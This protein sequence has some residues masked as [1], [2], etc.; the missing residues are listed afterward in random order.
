MCGIV[1]IV[2]TEDVTGALIQGLKF[3]EYRGY[4]SAGIAVANGGGIDIERS[5]GKIA[6]LEELLAKRPLHGSA[7]IAH[8][9]WATHGVPSVNN[10]HPH[11]DYT[12][13]F[14]VVHNGII[15]NYLSLKEKLRAEGVEFSSDTDT[16]VISH[17]IGHFS[18]RG[19][20]FR[21]AVMQTCRLLVGSFAIAVLSNKDKGTIIA[22]RNQTP[23][24]VGIGKGEHFVASDVTAFLQHTK[25]VAYLDDGEM[26]VVTLDKAEYYRIEDG[27]RVEK[28]IEHITWNVEEAQKAGYPHYMLKEIHQQPNILVDVLRGRFKVHE[29]RLHM[30]EVEEFFT[31][32][33]NHVSIIA[34]GTSWHAGLVAKFILEEIA[35]IH[36]TVDYASEFRYRTP[37]VDEGTV[38][39]AISQSGETADTLAA[40]RMVEKM[41]RKAMGICNVVGSSIARSCGLTLYT[42]AGPEISVA[43][44]K[45]FTSQ[46]ATVYLLA[47][48]IAEMRGVLDREKFHHYLRELRALPRKLSEVLSNTEE[49]K[50]WAKMFHKKR[51]FLFLGRGVNYPV[52]LEGA[53]KLKEIS[54][55]HAEG[56]PAG[57]M[58]HGPIALI[59]D[60]FPTVVV[61]PASATFEKVKANL[62]EV[63]AREGDVL[64]VTNRPD[65]FKRYT[66]FVFAIPDVD[67]LFSPILT[68]AP[69]QLF[70]YYTALRRG[71]SID[72][73]RNL[74][75]SVVVE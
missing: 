35:R 68:T 56:Y 28:K 67:E 53:L 61:A 39:L 18:E 31:S 62:E 1:G 37:M 66:P 6:M 13:N 54:Y 36:T 32:D 43:S 41:G 10:A 42:Q 75:K 23:L 29:D 3:L 72:Q 11:I 26:A 50:R 44:T 16:E 5:Q 33:I 40:V 8:T 69:L 12:G 24:C 74:A 2:R 4:D 25:D 9:R 60:D 59:D 64:V 46:L 19:A 63:L 45:A 55:I 48:K 49:L 38:T 21:D 57:E 34:C 22:A 30:P 58:K 47:I 52:A 17:L 65:E 70:A 73:P 27:A 7:G 51:N 14:C 20:G 71:C 15:E